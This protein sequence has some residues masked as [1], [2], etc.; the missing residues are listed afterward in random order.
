MDDDDLNVLKYISSLDFINEEL[1]KNLDDYIKKVN[2]FKNNE[3]PFEKEI[4]KTKFDKRYVKFC[5][6][7]GVLLLII[8]IVIIL[9]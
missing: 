9:F 3:S 6:I 4:N 5:F 1:K 8:S 7:L 2:D